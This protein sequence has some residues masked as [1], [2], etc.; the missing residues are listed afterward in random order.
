[1]GPSVSARALHHEDAVTRIPC[2]CIGWLMLA[3]GVIGAVVPLMPTT[4]F[5]ILAA[6]FFARSSPR[7]EARLLEHPRFGPTLAAWREGG[8]ITAPAKRAA[9]TGMAVGFTLFWFGAH[10]GPWLTATAAVFML[11]SAAYVVSCPG[12]PGA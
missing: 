1:M 6:W 11:A 2:F 3:L 5:L 9:C 12:V 8:A 4:I 10:P 7:L